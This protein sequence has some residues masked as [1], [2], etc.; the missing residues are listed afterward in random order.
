MKSW[1]RVGIWGITLFTYSKD[2]WIANIDQHSW[3]SKWKVDTGRG[4][5]RDQ[6]FE[7]DSTEFIRNVFWYSERFFGISKTKNQKEERE[8]ESRSLGESL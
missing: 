1:K 5:F 3:N 2:E 6:I 4:K 7:F 8:K